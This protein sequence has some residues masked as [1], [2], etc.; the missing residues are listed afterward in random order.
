M[1]PRKRTQSAPQIEES[2]EQTAEA[3]AE[4]EP[5]PGGGDEASTEPTTD[6]AADAQG[7]D[8]ETGPDAQDGPHEPERSDIQAGEEP[9]GD[10]FPGGW[11][12]QAAVVGALGCEHGTWQRNPVD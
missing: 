11:A 4:P 3:V 12:A 10:C 7:G 2:N 1:P 9:C 6:E 8:A 5:E